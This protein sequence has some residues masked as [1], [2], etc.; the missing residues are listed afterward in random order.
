MP[1]LC[2][3]VQRSQSSIKRGQKATYV[4]QISTQN[5]SASDVSVALTAQPSSQKPT[6][7]SGCG[8]GNGTAVCGVK[9]V[10]TAQ[11]TS[12]KAQIAVAS[13][14][15][16]VTSVKLTATASVVTTATWTPPAAAMTT[17]VTAAAPA[18]SAK[19]KA[20][21]KAKASPA[22]PNLAVLPLGPIPALNGEASLLIG[23][24]NAAG[25]FPTISPSPR[26]SP[27]P[28]ATATATAT[29]QPTKRKAA[30]FSEASPV[31]LGTPVFTAQVAGL[32]ALGLAIMLTVTRL[33]LR[34]RSGKPRS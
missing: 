3:S 10:T 24:G 30:P 2:V 9:S 32:I 25:L 33:S 1:E 34:R 5:G 31:S 16:S 11:P 22:T 29:A 23:A 8:S 28:T 21:A 14:A 17:A 12:L 7:S 19:A 26:A 4:V 20:K 18:K 13:T 15:T 6:F 27:G